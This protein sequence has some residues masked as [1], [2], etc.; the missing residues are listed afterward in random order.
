MMS[1]NLTFYDVSSHHCYGV[2]TEKLEKCNFT[3]E[4]IVKR[5]IPK[6]L[7]AE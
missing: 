4:C 1:T 3:K 2:L 5:R 6:I 7:Y